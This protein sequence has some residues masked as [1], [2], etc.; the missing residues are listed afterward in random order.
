[1][2]CRVSSVSFMCISGW[3]IDTLCLKT[4]YN[5]NSWNNWYYYMVRFIYCFRS[6]W[7]GYSVRA[8]LFYLYFPVRECDRMWC[9]ACVYCRASC[10]ACISGSGG[11]VAIGYLVWGFISG[12]IWS[13]CTSFYVIFELGWSQHFVYQTTD[14]KRL[15]DYLGYFRNSNLY[16]MDQMLWSFCVLHW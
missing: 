16:C 13:S 8:G 1:M 15:G 3:L 7:V 5:Y 12:V 14:G 11:D 9:L 2:V 4:K 10:V 6:I